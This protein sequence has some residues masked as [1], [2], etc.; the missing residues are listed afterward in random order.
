MSA[1]RI[2]ESIDRLIGNTPIVHLRRVPEGVEAIVLAKLEAFNSGGSVKDRS[3]LARKDA[4]EREEVKRVV[5][6]SAFSSWNQI[7]SDHLGF[8]GR[9]IAARGVDADDAVRRLGDRELMVVHG[10]D[11]PIVPVKHASII[12]DA[13]KSAGVPT[14]LLL[15]PQREHNDMLMAGS[16]E[17][18]AV[19]IFLVE[20]LQDP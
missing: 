13:A 1:P 17:A 15:V 8:L 2:A 11:D 14:L 6:V 16:S 5:S 3:W 9:M 12:A 10:Q 19:A 4:A 20:G 18:E 7:A